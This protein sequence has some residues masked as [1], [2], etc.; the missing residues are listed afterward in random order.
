[1]NETKILSLDEIS[2]VVKK[3]LVK[4][5]AEYALLF[6][7]YARGEANTQSDVDIVVFGGKDFNLTDI[8]DFS[9]ELREILLKNIDAYEIREIKLG[10]HLYQN[11]IKDGV[12]IA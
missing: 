12:K 10:S 8:L 11:I 3:L 5:H 2:S 7:S 6:G 1:M 9:E 4:Y